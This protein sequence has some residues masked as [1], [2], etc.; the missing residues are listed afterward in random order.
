MH[1]DF[2]TQRG[3]YFGFDKTIII[4]ILIIRTQVIL[5]LRHT[6]DL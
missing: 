1:V 4:I 6:E 5:Q 3:M 2:D